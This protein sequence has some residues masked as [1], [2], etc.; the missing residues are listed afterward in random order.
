MMA[1]PTCATLDFRE[2]TSPPRR[3]TNRRSMFTL[4]KRHHMSIAPPLPEPMQTCSSV[5]KSTWKYMMEGI[6]FVALLTGIIGVGAALYGG[7]VAYQQ[8]TECE[9]QTGHSAAQVE[10]AVKQM[11][12]ANRDAKTGV[13][14]DYV[15][16]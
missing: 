16:S 3:I 5:S 11:E 10:L 15:R 9:R 13:T 4:L 7:R 12:Q 2:M 6:K 1:I 8:L 14:L